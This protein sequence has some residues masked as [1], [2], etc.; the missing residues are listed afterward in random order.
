MVGRC[1]G[2]PPMTVIEQKEATSLAATIAGLQRHVEDWGWRDEEGDRLLPPEM[3]PD[4]AV[5]AIMRLL[6]ELKGIAS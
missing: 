4:K 3:Q 1:A 6:P 2:A 5:A